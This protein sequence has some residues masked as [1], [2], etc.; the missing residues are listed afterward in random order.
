MKTLKIYNAKVLT[1]FRVISPGEVIISGDRI[2]YVGATRD[3]GSHV[4][5]ET[6]DAQGLYV[7]PGFVDIHVHGGGGGDAMDGDVKSIEAI[8]ATHAVGG[9]TSLLLTTLTAPFSR[10]VKALK[11]VE[12]AMQMDGHGARVLGAHLEGPYINPEYAGAQNPEFIC[13]PQKEDYIPILNRYKCIKRVSFA[14]E[15]PGALELAQELRRRGIVASIAHSGA[16][17]SNVLRAIEV[18]CSHVTHMF[19]GMSGIRRVSGYRVAGVVESTLLLDELTT[20]L[21]ADGHH[22][23]PSLLKLVVKAKGV[24]RL[25]LV[26]DAIAAAGMGPGHYTL[27][28]LKI[29]VEKEVPEVFEVEPPQNSYVAKLADRTAFAGSV[30]T[31]DQLVRNMIRLGGVSLLDAVKM[32]TF[33]PARII[34]I[35]DI[36]VLRPGARADVTLFNEDVAVVMTIVGGRIMYQS[37]GFA[38]NP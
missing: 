32:A 33:N 9:T 18:G 6:L 17:Y 23:P 22:L 3:E 8:T 24:D 31:M 21:I 27:E 29:V 36:G 5:D 16:S 1:P 37:H 15:L 13:N 28:G 26:T 2:E 34:G 4:A 7:A 10:I 30:A 35:N 25:S 14:P 19:S 12:A 11:A 20:E 38:V